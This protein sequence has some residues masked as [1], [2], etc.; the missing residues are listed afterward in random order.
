MKIFLVWAQVSKTSLIVYTT[1]ILSTFS[2][3]QNKKDQPCIIHHFSYCMQNFTPSHQKFTV[4][5]NINTESFNHLLQK[6]RK[7][8]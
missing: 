1:V 5:N 8:H 6:H 3:T 7:Y 2:V 4:G